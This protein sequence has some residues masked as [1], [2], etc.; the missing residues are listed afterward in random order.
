[1]KVAEAVLSLVRE[2]RARFSVAEVAERSGVHRTTVYR[3][4]PTPSDLLREALTVHTARLTTPDEG[5]WAA[6]VSALAFSLADF[7]SDPVERAMNA[8][9]ASGTDP[10]GEEVQVEHW[11]PVAAGLSQIVDRAKCRGE[12]AEETDART[13]MYL[14]VSPLLM[15]TV[16]LHDAPDADLVRQLAAAV[17][18]AFAA[19]P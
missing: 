17:T 14:L 1:M 2:G 9:M 13:L 3:W 5:T 16:L 4:W 11:K 12:I 6:D 7:F 15:H 8:A 18:R 10:E 19:A